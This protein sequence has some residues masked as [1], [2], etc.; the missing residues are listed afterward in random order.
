MIYMNM[1]KRVNPKSCHY[2]ERKSFFISINFVTTGLSKSFICVFKAQMNF[3]ANP[4]YEM[5]DIH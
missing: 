3:L 2:K 5:M 1:V 4:L